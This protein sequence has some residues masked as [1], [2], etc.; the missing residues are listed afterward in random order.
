MISKYSRLAIGVVFLAIY[1]IQAVIEPSRAYDI[2]Y[3]VLSLY[4]LVN[5]LL[6]THRRAQTMV[7]I[8]IGLLIILFARYCID[9]GN[10]NGVKQ[11][12]GS[13]FF[14]FSMSLLERLSEKEEVSFKAFLSPQDK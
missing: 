12:L 9:L 4:L 11:A 14:L 1:I 5:A 2:F 3:L 10:M 8:A 7:Y 6:Y 13:V